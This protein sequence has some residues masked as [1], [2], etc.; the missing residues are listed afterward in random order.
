M[1]HQTTTS[2][3]IGLFAN[4]KAGK[5]KA[6]HTA[7]LLATFLAKQYVE[8]EIFVGDWPETLDQL[9]DAW[10]IGGD[11]TVNY[12]INR[13][14]PNIM[15]SL[16]PTGTGNDFHWQLYGKID[17]L[18]QANKI[19]HTS[20]QA[21][22]V[23]TCNGKWYL[24]SVGLGFDGVVLQSMQ[25]IR[26][27]GGHLGY[28]WIVIKTIFSFKEYHFT[29]QKGDKLIEGKYL[30]VA[31][32]N[33]KRTGGGFMITPNASTTDGL[34][35]MLLCK[36]LPVL[37]RLRYLPVIERG[38]HLSLPFI[39]HEQINKISITCKEEISGQ[40]DGELITG[41]YFEFN[42]LPGRL[43]FSVLES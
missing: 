20:T 27:F 5:G 13:Y 12:F 30:L 33:S 10:I 41:K 8:H 22:D 19:L 24:N 42:V 40:M 23:I 38:K 11:G 7:N 43:Q 31:I 2:K 14:Q 1:S 3:K 26:S 37:K 6:M 36:A 9:T 39:H 34:M 32:N 16:F 4:N 21:V 29:I 35:D 18:H 28:L 25:K 17:A 15:L